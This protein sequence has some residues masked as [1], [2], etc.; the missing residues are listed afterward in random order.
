MKKLFLGLSLI[1]SLT[2]FAQKK[3]WLDPGVNAINRAPMRTA[4]FAY[5]CEI[6]IKQ[7][8]K[9]KIG[10]IFRFPVFGNLT[11]TGIRYTGMLAMP[12]PISSGLIRPW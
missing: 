6:F 11:V 8:L 10:L 2:T 1:L 12:G 3:E 5:P 4:N 7:I 9:T